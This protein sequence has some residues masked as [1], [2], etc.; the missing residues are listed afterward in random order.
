MKRIMAFILVFA[1][2]TGSGVVMWDRWW[3]EAGLGSAGP[4][5]S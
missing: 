1:I 3:R 2:L 4:N 5:L